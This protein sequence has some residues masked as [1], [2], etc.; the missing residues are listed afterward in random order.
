MP[1]R[2]ISEKP[3]GRVPPRAERTRPTLRGIEQRIDH[4][5]V[6]DEI[7]VAD[8]HVFLL[9]FALGACIQ[10]ARDAADNLPLAIGQKALRVTVFKRRILSRIISSN[11]TVEHI[12]HIIRV[13]AIQPWFGNSMYLMNSRG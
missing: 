4:F 6:I 2:S 5:V 9:N 10:D 3:S 12:R 1:S 7:D 11:L 8:V 13:A